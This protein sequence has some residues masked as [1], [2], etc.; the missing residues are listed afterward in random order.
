MITYLA[1]MKGSFHTGTVLK[2]AGGWPAA[3]VR[4]V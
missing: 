1:T 2:F 4:P 3:P